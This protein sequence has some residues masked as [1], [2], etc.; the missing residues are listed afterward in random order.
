MNKAIIAGCLLALCNFTSTMA[1]TKPVTIKIAQT[2][3]VHGAF[4]PTNFINS[5]PT[6]GSLARVS[7]YVNRE[8][9]AYGRNLILLENGDILQGQPLSYYSNYIDTLGKNIAAEVVNYLHYDA[10]AIGNHD[11]E[12]GHKVYDK[13][14]AE[15]NC[16][17]IGANVID[18]RTGKP[19]LKP[20]TIMERDG[21]KIGVLGLITPAI[22]NWL[23]RELWT[24]LYFENMA[25]A[26]RRWV[27]VMQ[28]E[29]KADVIV[30]LFHSGREGGITTAEYMEDASLQVAREVPGFNVVMFGHDHTRFSQTITNVAGKPVVCLDPAN[31]AMTVA[32]A[33][34]TLQKQRGKWVVSQCEGRLQSMKDEE[35]DEAYVNHFAGFVA[36]VNEYVSQKIGDFKQAIYTRDSYFGNS[37]FNDLILNLQQKITGADISFNAP[38]SFDERIEAGPVYVS[39]MFKLYKFENQLYVMRLTGEEIRKYLEMSYNQWVNTMSSADS[40]LL[41]LDSTTNGDAQRMGF[42]HFTFNFDSAAGIDYEVDVTKPEGQKVTILRM[43]D[44]RPFDPKASYRVALNSYRGNGGG[45]LLTKG[46]GIAQDSLASRIVWRSDKDQRHYLM[47]EIRKA[48]IMDPQPNHNWRFV[49]EDIVKPAAERDYRLL[50]GSRPNAAASTSN[51]RK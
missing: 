29:E 2:S 18:T 22:P 35:I 12:T 26:A 7:S 47:E 30:G 40:H 4:F 23:P 25:T 45:E 31:N 33:T 39:D 51:N 34:L 13:W 10:Q 16:P 21:V 28:E 38:L 15:L 20:Y 46:A 17:V 42:R 19:Y 37:A 14:I 36:K 11:V 5:K 43:S 50:F 49:P 32:E 8:R 24:N 27:K 41:L 6:G 9:R 44:G 48:G 3:D 1:K